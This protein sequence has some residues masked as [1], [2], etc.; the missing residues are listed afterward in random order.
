MDHLA[1]GEAFR[2]KSQRQKTQDGPDFP[3]RGQVKKRRFGLSGI[4][5]L[6][7]EIVVDPTEQSAPENG[8]PEPKDSSSFQT[9]KGKLQT[10]QQDKKESG[11]TG[12]EHAEFDLEAMAMNEAKKEA[13]RQIGP[14][15]GGKALGG[16]Q[17]AEQKG[18]G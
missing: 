7:G 15:N 16:F 4:Q 17:L 10:E 12:A 13:E 1:G 5:V 18:L 2:P 11:A 14:D 9:K 3:S 8:D 6:H